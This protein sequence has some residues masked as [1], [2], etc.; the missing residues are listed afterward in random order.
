MA[1]VDGRALLAAAEPDWKQRVPHCPEWDVAG[2]VRHTASI[3]MWMAAIVASGGQVSRRTLSPA[4]EDPAGLASCYVESLD[5]VLAVLGSADPNAAD[6]DVLDYWRPDGALV[7]PAAGGRGGDP[8][9]GRPARRG[10]RPRPR[11]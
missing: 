5:Q 2:L 8:P 3:F 11:T 10:H 9:L 1:D 6:L 4:P 7:V